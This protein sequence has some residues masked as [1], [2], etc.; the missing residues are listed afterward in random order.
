MMALVRMRTVQAAAAYLREQD[1]NT[2]IGA[3]W[4]SRRISDGSLP[5][6]WAGTRRLINLDTLEAYL[7]GGQPVLPSVISNNDNDFRPARMRRID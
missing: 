6:V 2:A 4:I 5:V 3:G 1:P 7:A